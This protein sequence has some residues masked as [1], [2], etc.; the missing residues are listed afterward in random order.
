MK[1]QPSLL[2][3]AL[4]AVFLLLAAPAVFAQA[5]S[6]PPGKLTYQGFLTDH[7][8]L[9]LGN[10]TPTNTI[11]IFRIYNALTAGVNKWSEQQTVTIDKGHF[12]VLLGEGSPVGS[13]PT[14]T[15]L[16]PY[17]TGAD[18]SDRFM[19]ITVG[20][21]VITPRLQFQPAPYAMLANSARQLVDATGA[22][23][24]TAASGSMN[25]SGSVTATTVT[26]TT[27]TGTHV[28]NG[29]IPIGGIIMW[30]GATNAIPVGWALCNGATVN[31]VPT[32]NLIDRFI[33]GAG[34]G[35]NNVGNVGGVNAVLLTDNQVPLRAH[36]HTYRDYF[37]ADIAPAGSVAIL[38]SDKE[39]MGDDVDRRYHDKTTSSASLA[40]T[41]PFDNRPA[42]FALAFIMRVQ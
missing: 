5:N 4:C 3:A 12:S 41:V 8:G 26:A 40:A 23:I 36:T 28:G 29:T 33:V 2:V 24:I 7:E 32:P 22:P 42:F 27:V 1:K 21:T 39:A 13:E 10:T 38:G 18:A 37:D 14:G 31:G 6:S 19:E 9:P 30:S 25:F 16:T 20:T 34:S 17:F 35:T 15:S 11:V